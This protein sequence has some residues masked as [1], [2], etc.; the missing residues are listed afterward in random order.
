MKP[1]NVTGDSWHC[2]RLYDF[3]PKVRE[4]DSGTRMCYT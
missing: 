1:V 2:G 3:V 4:M